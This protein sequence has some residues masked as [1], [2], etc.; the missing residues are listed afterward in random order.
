MMTATR[1]KRCPNGFAPRVA[2]CCALVLLLAGCTHT[3]TPGQ[4]PPIPLDVVKARDPGLSVN[5][6]NNQPNTEPQLFASVG[7]HKHYANYNEWT[8]FFITYWSEELAKRNVTVSKQ[9]PNTILVKLDDFILT[10]GFAKIRTNMTVRLSSPDDTWKRSLNETDTSGWSLGRAFGSLIYHAV[11]KMLEDSE[12]LARMK[13][14][15][16][17]N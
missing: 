4:A 7:G 17:A 12:I 15:G 11:E 13:P 8:E 2:L 1:R 16:R 10:R 5:L 3:W 6:V 14:P 9:S